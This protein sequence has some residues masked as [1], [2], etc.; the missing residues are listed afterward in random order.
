MQS[1][2]AQSL[3]SIRDFGPQEIANTAWACAQLMFFDAPLLHAPSRAA[4][5]PLKGGCVQNITNTAWAFAQLKY[6]NTT[7]FNSISSEVISKLPEYRERDMSIMAWSFARREVRDDTLLDAISAAAIRRRCQLIGRA[8]ELANL[9]WAVAVCD[10]RDGTLLNSI[11]SAAIPTCIEKFT[12]QELTNLLWSFASLKCRHEPLLESIASSARTLS[13][14]AS[15]QN[16]VNTAWALDVLDWTDPQGMLHMIRSFAEAPRG[17]LGVEWTTLAAIVEKEGL[18]SQAPR[19]VRDFEALVLRPVVGHL[20][21]VRQAATD[22]VLVERMKAFQEWVV[23]L[24]APKR[25]LCFQ[26]P[27]SAPRTLATPSSPL[28]LRPG[29]SKPPR[30][31]APSGS[32]E[33]ARLSRQLRGGVAPTP[34]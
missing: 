31:T 32:G 7:F 16:L 33:P 14:Q 28:G 26:C 19:F 4:I 24:Q 6:K 10:F 18:A 5:A 17:A 30:R 1:I 29:A 21:A 2:S 9:A 3:A 12:A 11:A 15:T 25:Q 13:L 34:P 27:A 8:Q 23:A 20:A 22:A